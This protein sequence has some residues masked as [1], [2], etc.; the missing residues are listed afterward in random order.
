[1]LTIWTLLRKEVAAFFNSLIAYLVISVFLVGVGLFFW[2][3]GANVLDNGYASLGV[4]FEMA[5]WFYL[6]LVPAITMRSLAEEFKQGT[7]EFLATKP[8]T[9]WQIVLGKYLAA[10]VLVLFALLPTLV[11]FVSVFYLASPTGNVDTGAIAGSYLGLFGIGC[12][13][14]AIGLFAS[15][16]TDNQIVAFVLGAFLCFVFYA[17]FDFLAELPGLRAYSHVILKLGI[18]EHYGSISRGVVDSRDVVYY[19]SLIGGFLLLSKTLLST[20]K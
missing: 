4:L 12:V 2:V 5:P 14:A 18:N 8:L 15:A 6:F 16:L 20:R 9:D 1:M 10:V 19:L 7:I 17:A 13:F 3:F 11:Y